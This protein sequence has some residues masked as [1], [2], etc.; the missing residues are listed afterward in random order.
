MSNKINYKVLIADD[1][2]NWVEIYAEWVK[3]FV[4][5]LMLNDYFNNDIK[6]ALD[7]DKAFNL[8]EEDEDINV[9]ISD[10]FMNPN[11]RNRHAPDKPEEPFGGIH[12]ALK[13]KELLKS[14]KREICCL[15]VS[16]KTNAA[17]Y[18]KQWIPEGWESEGFIKFV[19]KSPREKLKEELLGKTYSAFVELANIGRIINSK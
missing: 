17:E 11:C 3:R 12:L 1:D 15:L 10:V 13:I 6:Q 14:K 18:F 16:D 8:I 2:K 19:D 9:I 7:G 5:E 4:K